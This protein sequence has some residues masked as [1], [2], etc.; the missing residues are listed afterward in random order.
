MGLT[1]NDKKFKSLSGLNFK[2]YDDGSTYEYFCWADAGTDI[3]DSFWAVCRLTKA[4]STIDWADGDDNY[5]NVATD[6]STVAA[7]TFT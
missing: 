2:Y 4:D 6:L 3:D 7:L 1:L 5:D